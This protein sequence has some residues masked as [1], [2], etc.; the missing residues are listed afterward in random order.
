MKE[1]IHLIGKIRL[2]SMFSRLHMFSSPHIHREKR[3]FLRTALKE[4]ATV[5]TDQPGLLGP[6]ALYIFVALSLA[7]DEFLW[8]L[9]HYGSPPPRK[10]NVK[11]NDEDF[12]DRQIPELMFHLEELRGLCIKSIILFSRIY[13]CYIFNTGSLLLYTICNVYSHNKRHNNLSMFIVALVKKYDQVMQRYYIQYLSGYDAAVL[14][15]HILVR[16]GL[17]LR[18]VL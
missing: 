9:R 13:I 17:I 6:K 18:Q 2:E 16:F 12:V 10:A 5:F 1:S 15:Q 3:K 7:R 8:L 11:W 14:N 4:L